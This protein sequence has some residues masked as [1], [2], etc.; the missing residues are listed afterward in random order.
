[1]SS[2]H[3]VRD[4]LEQIDITHRFVNAYPDTF[5]LCTNPSAV[6]TAFA[7]GKIA[8]MLGV[9]GGH[10]TGNS[11]ATLRLFFDLGVRYMTLTH[12]SDN[13]FGTSWITVAPHVPDVKDTGLTNFGEACVLEMNRL[14]ML[15]DLSH[16]SH[17][18][19]RDAL[20]V[21]KAPVIFSHSASYAMTK[22]GRN[23][24]DDV[25]H[26]VKAN[27]GVVMVPSVP[28]FLR[29]PEPG[30]DFTDATATVEDY[31]DH[32]VHIAE[33]IGWEHVGV[34]SDF[35]GCPVTAQG[36]EV[37]LSVPRQFSTH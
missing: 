17:Q 35:D 34:G 32:V 36:L 26:M 30:Q 15:V 8:S 20:R 28:Y 23:V 1:M 19:M 2:Q 12:N 6:R 7:S 9:E 29:N 16:V 27:G 18:T 37:V 22:V 11:I 5:T 4:T 31:L 33:L 24:P 25:L 21:T 14:G 13:A 10:S 3:C